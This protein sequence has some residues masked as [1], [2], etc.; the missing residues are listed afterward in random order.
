MVEALVFNHAA[1]DANMRVVVKAL[2][3]KDSQCKVSWPG[4]RK[5]WQRATA[6]PYQEREQ[7]RKVAAQNPGLQS[8]SCH[9]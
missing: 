5:A 6:N 7:L 8:A 2:T 1:N 9:V 3:C 4:E